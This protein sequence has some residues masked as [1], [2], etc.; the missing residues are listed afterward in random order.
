M[1]QK[2]VWYTLYMNSSSMYF[3]LVNDINM[4]KPCKERTIESGDRM[5]G[6][7]ENFFSSYVSWGCTFSIFKRETLFANNFLHFPFLKIWWRIPAYWGVYFFFEIFRFFK[8]G[9]LFAKKLP[10]L[11]IFL[12]IWWCNPVSLD[13][14]FFSECLRGELCFL[15]RLP[16]LSLFLKIGCN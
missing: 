12:K 2:F 6:R 8:R 16:H 13:V 3:K 9:T 14:F 10:H 1:Y 15:K 4:I 5:L 7:C 11:S